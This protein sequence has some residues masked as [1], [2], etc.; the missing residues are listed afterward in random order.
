MSALT[1]ATIIVEAGETSGTLTQARAALRQGR[2]LFVLDSCFRSPKLTWPAR[3]AQRGVIRVKDALT[4]SDH[5]YL[6][7]GDVPAPPSKAKG[8]PLYDNRLT[9]MI[10]AV[11]PKPPLDVCELIAQTVSTDAVHSNDVRPTPSEFDTLYRIDEALTKPGPAQT[12][13]LASLAPRAFQGHTHSAPPGVRIG[14]DGS[15]AR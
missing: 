7:E 6:T 9:Q 13:E 10:D 12:P 14:D 8:D 4:R 1:E 3:F 11:R 5:A 15:S 2:K